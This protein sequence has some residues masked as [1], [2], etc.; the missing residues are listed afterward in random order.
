LAHSNSRTPTPNARH[1]LLIAGLVAGAAT[2]ASRTVPSEHA[3][4]VI[5]LIFLG[6]TYWLCLRGGQPGDFGLAGG[7]L[8]ER[9][10][11]DPGRLARECAQALAWSLAV[12]VVVF[13]PFVIGFAIWYQ[14]DLPFEWSRAVSEL[15]RGSSWG[16]AD[17]VLGHLLV[18]ALPEEAFFRGYLQSALDRRW[19]TPLRGLGMDIGHGL[20]VSSAI[21][22]LGH[23][24]T[25]PH[26]AR[27]AVFFPSLLFG[28]LRA[29][30]GGIG[31]SIVFHATC[32]MVA[33]VLA[34]GYGFG[35]PP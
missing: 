29:R 32:N 31:A 20:W 27:L 7:G 22:A 34:A 18:V 26:P 19:G 3:A 8:L 17:L 28:L 4:S 13:P 15:G 24:A 35:A 21:F 30:T 2:F 6:A 12:S 14:P 23:V 33:A 11:L 16:L 25:T 5:G 1:V 10:P 9:E